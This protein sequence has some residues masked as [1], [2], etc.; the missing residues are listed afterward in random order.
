MCLIKGNDMNHLSKLVEI[1]E[2]LHRLV[3]VVDPWI[4]P[5]IEEQLQN[6]SSLVEY[7]LESLK[8]ENE[9]LE[10]EHEKL[11]KWQSR[12]SRI[13]EEKIRDYVIQ[14]LNQM[15]FYTPGMFLQRDTAAVTLTAF[16][17]LC[18]LYKT[19]SLDILP[20]GSQFRWGLEDWC[21]EAF[22]KLP[23]IEQELLLRS[24]MCLC[25]ECD[26]CEVMDNESDCLRNCGIIR[27]T[28]SEKLLSDFEDYLTDYFN[29][30]IETAFYGESNDDEE[31]DEDEEPE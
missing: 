21:M 14:K 31:E 24:Y 17:E 8:E 6:L 9:K 4:K 25:D 27:E 29:D 19:D 12:W 13:F 15:E 3:S 1:F 10:E 2:E 18:V 16:E 30:N 5:R 28:I 23:E 22:D 11:E 26:N 7:E 20:G